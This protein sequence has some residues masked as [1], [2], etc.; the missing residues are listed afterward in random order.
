MKTIASVLAAG[1]LTVVAGPL[2]MIEVS[3]Q[4]HARFGGGGRFGAAA[5]ENI[6]L[7]AARNRGRTAVS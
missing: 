1:I 2:M 5:R 7:P 4:A 6:F 3:D